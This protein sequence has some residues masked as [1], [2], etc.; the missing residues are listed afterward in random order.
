[1]S[2]RRTLDSDWALCPVFWLFGCST[3]NR[4]P[5]VQKKSGIKAGFF[6]VIHGPGGYSYWQFRQVYVKDPGN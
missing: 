6:R 1:M 4:S 5:P 2:V 3:D